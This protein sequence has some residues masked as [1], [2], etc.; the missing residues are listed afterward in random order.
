M[1]DGVTKLGWKDK[2]TIGVLS[3]VFVGVPVVFVGAAVYVVV[4]SW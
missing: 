2:L 4:T 3:V 1:L